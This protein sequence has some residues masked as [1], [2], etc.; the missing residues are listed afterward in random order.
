MV[1][2]PS[3]AATA[4]FVPGDRP[5]RLPK[6]LGSGADVV[7][8]DLEDA[9]ADAQKDRARADLAEALRVGGTQVMVRVNAA[10]TSSFDAD[11]DLVAEFGVEEGLLGVLIAKTD[12]ADEVAAVREKAR[13]G[14]EI[15][16]L[17][18]SA[19][20]LDGLRQIAS[21]PGIHR[22]A[23]G[24]I[25]LA[26][27][28]DTTAAEVLDMVRLQLVV[29]SRAAGLAP[30]LDSPSVEIRDLDAVEESACRA[31]SFGFGGKLCIHP[32]QLTAVQAAFTPYG[33][34]IAWARRVLAAGAEGAAQWEGTMIDKPVIERARRILDRS[35]GTR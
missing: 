27:D 4:L 31:R 32:A 11:L 29:A 8:V 14:V 1:M 34:E 25:D 3:R 20:G 10:E 16:A 2:M 26:L 9:V 19:R 15:I 22:L 23:F 5:D 12:S 13:P 33:D 24:A 17:I 35:V 28:L 7:I 6:A 18:E 21:A 30:P